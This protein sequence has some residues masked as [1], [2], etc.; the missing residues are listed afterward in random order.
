MQN[1][2][3]ELG[4]TKLQSK[5]PRDL[6]RELRMYQ[7]RLGTSAEQAGD[8]DRV[9]HIAHELNNHITAAYLREAAE[10]LPDLSPVLTAVGKRVLAR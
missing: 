7:R 6:H 1:T 2:V 10:S 3:S 9:L 8:F 4:G 5:S